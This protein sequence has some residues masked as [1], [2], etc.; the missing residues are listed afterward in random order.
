M[1]PM[2]RIMRGYLIAAIC[3]AEQ[4]L[5][6]TAPTCREK[7]QELR[8]MELVEE[9][10]LAAAAVTLTQTTEQAIEM[11]RLI[12]KQRVKETNQKTYMS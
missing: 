2:E 8:T 3:D 4:Y 9:S 7:L 6:R 10:Q 5:T 12:E 1:N 11:R